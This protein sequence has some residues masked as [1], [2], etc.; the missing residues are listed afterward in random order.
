MC[1]KAW[2]ENHLEFGKDIVVV[3]GPIEGGLPEDAAAM[4]EWLATEHPD[5]AADTW[6]GEANDKRRQDDEILTNGINT[7][8]GRAADAIRDLIPTT[9]NTSGASDPCSTA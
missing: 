3:L 2:S 9:R 4:L 7:T 5:P 8:R 6:P 1:R